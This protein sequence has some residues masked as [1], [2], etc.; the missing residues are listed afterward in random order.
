MHRA[1]IAV[2]FLY[3]CFI[4]E[5]IVTEQPFQSR[6]LLDKLSYTTEKKRTLDAGLNDLSKQE[7]ALLIK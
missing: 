5:N 6:E 4:F 3:F 7:T 2:A 1:F